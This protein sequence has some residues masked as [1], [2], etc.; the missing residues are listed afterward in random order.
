MCG[1]AL[2]L[3]AVEH[4]AQGAGLA[5]A[6]S[7]HNTTWRH[8]VTWPALQAASPS[9]PPPPPPSAAP[10]PSASLDH[11]R[12]AAVSS[13][14]SVYCPS[15][16]ELSN[17]L[18]RRGPD[19]QDKTSVIVGGAK[20]TFI[21][22]CILTWTQLFCAE[23]QLRGL[24]QVS[25]P[26]RDAD[27][28]ILLFNGEVFGGL[29]VAPE[30]NDADVL[31]HALANCDANNN[32]PVPSV[33]SQ[34]RGPWA[35]IYWQNSTRTLWFG[36]DAIGRRSLLVHMPTDSDSRF[37]MTSTAARFNSSISAHV[38]EYWHDV[39]TGLHSI[40]VSVTPRTVREHPWE[41]SLLQTIR[42]QVRTAPIEPSNASPEELYAAT[43]SFLK[44]L[45]E[46]AIF[47]LTAICAGVGDSSCLSHGDASVA[48]LFSGGVDSM[49]LAALA[50][51]HIP[52]TEPIDLSNVC[53][54]GGKSPDRQTARAGLVELQRIAPQRKW[55]L[56]EVDMDIDKDVEPC[57][58]KLMALICPSRTFMDFNIA[59]ALWHAASLKGVTTLED[60]SRTPF[61][62]K[63][64]VV[65]L[66]NGADE[67]C[68]GYG[69]HQTKLRETGWQGLQEELAVDVQRLWRRNLG[70]D[71][72]C[73]ADHGRE[74]RFPFLDESVMQFLLSLPLTTV[75]DPRLPS[76]VGDKRIIRSA[77]KLLGLHNASCLPKRAI[78]F[79]TRIAQASNLRNYSSNR[80]A[81][82]ANIGG[83]TLP[84]L[85]GLR[86]T[87]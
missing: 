43:A 83:V 62:S 57:K 71:D 34:L 66:G 12:P 18:A 15:V 33:L 8:F 39:P 50:H 36:R 77:T 40:D 44:M 13:N 7:L 22:K 32:I 23:L 78:Q 47:E 84:G 58:D 20:L 35:V 16:E 1:I 63:A 46:A 25:Q 74:A 87:A 79:G 11:S 59:A 6:G 76:G 49:L 52:I 75:A 81:N 21:G 4:V 67:Q 27:G 28:N 37:I 29:P 82:A 19:A 70:R 9:P 54:F 24:Q 73:V 17:E 68:A 30:E 55:R 10:E 56:I 51:E 60:G 41:D 85:E 26:L 14:S 31:L 80:A 42:M 64:R 38:F 65:L 3:E 69:R 2:V 72:R 45:S 53:F 61:T 86:T 48:V 5:K